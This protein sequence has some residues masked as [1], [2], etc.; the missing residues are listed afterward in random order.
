MALHIPIR[1]HP[2]QTDKIIPD[3][4]QSCSWT[5]PMKERLLLSAMT[6]S[7]SMP[8]NTDD[9]DIKANAEGDET[10]LAVKTAT[11]IT[12]YDFALHEIQHTLFPPTHYTIENFYPV[13]SRLL[14]A[15]VKNQNEP[16]SDA[17]GWHLGY[18]INNSDQFQW[19][20]LPNLPPEF[21]GARC[22]GMWVTGGHFW[23]S[24]QLGPKMTAIYAIE[25]Q[26]IEHK[27][28]D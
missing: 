15:V 16:M 9:F 10:I 18:F 26:K 12:L 6:Q 25:I 21:Q 23:I 7:R 3:I 1:P 2:I 27:N 17:N 24:Q 28:R 4:V 22:Q 20:M 11:E 14:V 13:T 5:R 8:A 19:F